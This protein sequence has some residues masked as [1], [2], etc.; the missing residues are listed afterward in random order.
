MVL[1]VVAGVLATNGEKFELPN[2][3]LGFQAQAYPP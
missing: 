2:L 3:T 1:G